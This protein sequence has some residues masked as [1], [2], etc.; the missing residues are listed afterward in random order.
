MKLVIVHNHYR[1]GGVRRVIEMATPY[2]TSLRPRRFSSITI[3]SGETIETQWLMEFRKTIAPLSVAVAVHSLLSYVSEWTTTRTSRTARLS[4]FLQT[5]INTDDGNDCVVWAHNQSLARNVLL[6]RALVNICQRRRIKLVLHHHDW[7]FDNRWDRFQE[8]RALNLQSLNLIA[9]TLLSVKPYVHHIVINKL[10][11]AMLRPCLGKRVTWLPNLTV[12][13]SPPS[14]IECASTRKWLSLHTGSKGPYWLL[15][16]R[17]LRRKNICESLLLTRW[18][19]PAARLVTTGGVSSSAEMNY[20]VRIGEAARRHAWPLDLSILG[21]KHRNS[22][23]V[24]SLM[25]ASEAIILTS[26]QEGFG[27]PYLEAVAAG[28]PLILRRLPNVAPDLKLFG[29]RFSYAYDEVLIDPTIM[30][31]R[32]E[33]KRQLRLF[34]H[35]H[36]RLPSAYRQ[37]AHLPDWLGDSRAPGQI[38]FSRLTL[39]AQLEI[40]RI[41][42][43]ESRAASLSNNRE[44]MSWRQQADAHQLQIDPWPKTAQLFLSGHA[45]AKTFHRALRVGQRK[46]ISE[47]MSRA[48]Q[49]S[50]VRHRLDPVYQYP[51]LWNAVT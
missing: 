48:C 10:D 23:S 20:A 45:Y 38:P 49:D 28:R 40:L 29:F 27:L 44:L 25:A 41:P 3:L 15:P 37:L 4:Q 50:F 6:T 12:H 17:L 5:Q 13:N 31:W 35:W 22:P 34:D 43:D 8:L 14:R 51:L 30:D 26:L 46:A 21:K 2:I 9:T 11:G 42:S 36:G 32:S 24:H 7:W 47:S 18:L 16:C 33:R 1:P 19:N 39:T